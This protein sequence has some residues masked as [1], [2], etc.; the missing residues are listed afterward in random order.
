MDYL[1]PRHLVSEL[2]DLHAV[3]NDAYEETIKANLSRLLYT[4]VLAVP[5]NILHIAMF[6]LRAVGNPVEA[7]WRDLII[8][9]HT[10]LMVTM[11]GTAVLSLLFAR[12]NALRP[13]AEVLQY[14]V[15]ALILVFGIGITLVDQL[16]TPS[17][18]PYLIACAITAVMFLMRPL[19]AVPMYV[20]SFGAMYG[21][22]GVYQ[23][24]AALLL[25]GRVNAL[26]ASAIGIGLSSM[27]W[28]TYVGR[29][30]QRLRLEEQQ[31]ELEEKNRLLQF[32]ATHDEMTGLLNRKEFM[33]LVDDEIRRMRRYNEPTSII[34]AD[35]DRFKDLND[36]YGHPGGDAIL[37]EF[38]KLLREEVRA[39]DAVA[40]WGG[41]EFIILM[42]ETDLESATA[43]A[44]RLRQ[45]VER[46]RFELG[47]KSV[48]LTSSFGVAQVNPEAP[49]AF[50]IAYEAADRAMYGAKEAGRNRVLA[51]SAGGAGLA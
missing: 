30:R 44:E 27:L 32:M 7:R 36:R 9:S 42:P 41:E 2:M 3:S 11:I 33:R 43:A 17:I 25:S 34:L 35:I 16:V 49:D 1:Q 10:M 29:Y 6:W 20:V 5:M 23:A 13:A 46:C 22:L 38:A 21:L 4:A 50:A 28:T 45:Q 31:Y 18:T 14:I 8:M 19:A 26:T 51:Q 48:R 15:V 40:R 37:I 24:D 47:D 39:V 12:R